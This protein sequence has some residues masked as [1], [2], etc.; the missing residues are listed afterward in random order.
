MHSNNSQFEASE[1]NFFYSLKKIAARNSSKAFD[2]TPSTIFW[3][4][5]VD[6]N[7]Q[8]EDMTGD[9]SLGRHNIQN[10]LPDVTCQRPSLPCE[11][12]YVYK[13]G[14]STEKSS[15]R[16]RYR[17]LSV[18]EAGW[19]LFI[20]CAILGLV[21]CAPSENSRGRDNFFIYFFLFIV[22][23]ARIPFIILLNA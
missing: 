10:R 14:Y 23:S 17:N 7:K 22:S 5:K 1:A 21:V 16:G 3:S 20:F 13:Y 2:M 11:F 19:R 4:E 18:T 12:Q 15:L 9:T 6:K 8:Q